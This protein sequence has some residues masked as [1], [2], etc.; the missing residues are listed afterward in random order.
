MTYVCVEIFPSVQISGCV[1]SD[2]LY[3][4]CAWLNGHCHYSEGGEILALL[5]REL[6]VPYPWRCQVGWSPGQPELVGAPSPWKG[7]ELDGL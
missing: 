3:T 7:L 6:W 4:I 5:P 2:L 1:F